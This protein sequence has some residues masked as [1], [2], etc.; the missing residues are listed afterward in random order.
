M[1]LLAPQLFEMSKKEQKDWQKRVDAVKKEIAELESYFEEINSN[2]IYLGAFEWRIEF[3]EVLDDD[4]NFI[5][6]DLIIGNP[7]YM[8]IQEIR[9]NDSK[10]ADY[11]SL[12][13]KYKSTI[14]SFDIYVAFVELSR[15]ILTIGGSVALL[16]PIKWT[17][18]AFG[19]GLRSILT[20]NCE[21]K[22]ELRLSRVVDFGAYPIFEVSTYV[23]IQYFQKGT[24]LVRYVKYM[25]NGLYNHPN[26]FLLHLN[27]DSFS[28]VNV[29]AL[30]SNT[31]VFAEDAVAKILEKLNKLPLR[32]SDVFEKIYQGI[33]TSK[34]DVYFLY[35][36]EVLNNTVKGF[37]KQ[38]N[39]VVEIE[40]GLVKPLLKGEDVHRFKQLPRERFVIFPYKIENE[41]AILYSECELQSLFPKGYAYLKECEQILRGREKGRLQSDIFWYRYIYPKSLTCFN[42]EKLVAPEISIGGNFVYDIN[43]EFYHTTKVYG[44]IKKHNTP[45]SYHFLLALMNSTLFW[46]FLKHTGSVLRGGY[47]TFKTNYI[48]PFPIPKFQDI[49]QD[50]IIEIEKLSKK[51]IEL[52]KGNNV[53]S[54]KILTI[55]ID[56]LIASIY[57]LTQNE[58][59]ELC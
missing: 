41:K 6:F 12:S 23:G 26:E 36:C 39:R 8:R 50:R 32:L 47:Y 16:M 13:G 31:W 35:N 19:K 29:L 56:S 5:G 53:K 7:P 37:S 58:I 52:S 22:S 40:Q 18:A 3:P 51:I 20:Q 10:F 59:N 49:P 17:N 34:D 25:E 4:G 44:Y 14:G 28:N 33:A 27:T 45:Y 1:N 30:G 54:T 9:A 21:D 11:L 46:F 55:K 24:S 57:G 38:V 43:G 2:K 42:Q 48:M 15:M